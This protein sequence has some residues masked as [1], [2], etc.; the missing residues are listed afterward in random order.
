M[1]NKLW[2]VAVVCATLV[3]VG[4]SGNK[5]ELAA[6]DARI[7]E[8]ESEMTEMRNQLAS[9]T[10][11]N[12][13]LN[14]Q[15]NDALSEYQA[16]EQVWLEMEN[17]NQVITVSDA[18]LFGSG[19][20]D[21]IPE[22]KA[23]VDRIAGVAKQHPN[24]TIRVEGHSD[25]K[26]IGETLKDKYMSNW[27]LSAARACSITRYMYWKH[28]IPGAQLAAIGYGEHRPLG[29][30]DTPEG[31]SRNRRVVIVIGEEQN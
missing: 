16:K 22:G 5:Q 8:L 9:E 23:L 4:C 24:R 27:E 15:L 13:E 21:M 29:S 17:A 14:R 25:D 12:E 10:E 7:T 6:K 30:N 31:R 11:K 19:G 26:P 20:V 18:V 28:E 3:S 2:L 1:R